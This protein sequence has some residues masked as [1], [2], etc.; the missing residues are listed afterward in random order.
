MSSQVWKLTNTHVHPVRCNL[1]VNPHLWFLD[2]STSVLIW[3]NSHSMPTSRRLAGAL[4]SPN[5][6][7]SMCG[8]RWN[9]RTGRQKHQSWNACAPLWLQQISLSQLKG[10]QAVSTETALTRLFCQLEEIL[11]S[12]LKVPSS[13][14]PIEVRAGK[15]ICLS[16]WHSNTSEWLHI[17]PVLPR[18]S[19]CKFKEDFFTMYHG[20]KYQ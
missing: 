12:L 13:A 11:R 19:L 1:H 8:M 2:Q 15:W 7:E 5:N 17:F 10:S 14:K 18:Q 6:T 16:R 20:G 3:E 4:K 9:R